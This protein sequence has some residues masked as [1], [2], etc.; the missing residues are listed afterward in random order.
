MSLSHKW[1]LQDPTL[2][3]LFVVGHFLIFVSYMGIPLLVLRFLRRQ[4]IN[5][6]RYTAFW[7]TAAFIFSCGLSHGVSIWTTLVRPDYLLEGL[8]LTLT[9]II[10]AVTM[11]MLRPALT[12]LE[13]FKDIDTYRRVNHDL[14][15]QI[16]VLIMKSTEQ[17][18]ELEKLRQSVDSAA[19]TSSK[20][21]AILEVSTR[22][23]A[24]VLRL[25][26]SKLGPLDDIIGAIRD[27][28]GKIESKLT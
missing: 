17:A 21:W 4:R 8:L 15:S 10:S 7:L 26:D 14:R 18:H 24:E 6:T 28:A 2:V 27:L 20:G 13:G 11:V 1:Y 9:G 23:Q 3:T 12:Y 19:V 25:L 22:E 16:Q 5:F